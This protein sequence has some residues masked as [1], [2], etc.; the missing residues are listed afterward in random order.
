[1]IKNQICYA[2]SYACKGSPAAILCKSVCKK[3][4]CLK[5]LI[6]FLCVMQYALVLHCHMWNCLENLDLVKY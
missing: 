3:Q 4:F 2:R 6:E 1:M 5:N